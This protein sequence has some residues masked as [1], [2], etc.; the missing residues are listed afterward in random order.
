MPNGRQQTNNY[1][2]APNTSF[3][4]ALNDNVIFDREL[5][6]AF[7]A[8]ALEEHDHN[9]GE[10]RGKQVASNALSA[11]SINETMYGSLSIPERAYQDASVRTRTIA[12]GQVTDA[13]LANPKLNLLPQ[14]PLS[15]DL[16]ITRSAGGSPGDG[17][18]ILGNDSNW[19]GYTASGFQLYKGPTPSG[20][21]IFY[22]QGGGEIQTVGVSRT[23]QTSAPTTG[24]QYF[25]NS[26]A[27]IA[28]N[29][30]TFS[31]NGNPVDLPIVSVPL[32]SAVMF[33]TQAEFNAAGSRFTVDTFTNGRILVAAGSSGAPT[34]WAGDSFAANSYYGT[35]WTPCMGIAGSGSG[36]GGDLQN[37]L[38][39]SDPTPGHS[40]IVVP[41]SG[42]G[43]AGVSTSGH[44][45]TVTGTVPA[46]GAVTITGTGHVWMPPMLGVLWGRRTA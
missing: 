23:Y 42:S 29:G 19:L 36:G 15:S 4:W 10:G 11:A 28:W 46:G 16:R 40:I 30:S 34:G 21:I 9:Q 3:Q 43:A 1:R 24:V 45:H 22:H 25:G 44:I 18:L 7:L 33:R 32:Y 17:F 38:A 8:Q 14:S 37:G 27:N 39:A 12:D 6:L 20:T 41:G 5:D 2:G 31:I 35:T 26:S 13:K